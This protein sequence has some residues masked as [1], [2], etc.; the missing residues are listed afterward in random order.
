MK[1]RLVPFRM[2]LTLG[3]AGAMIILFGGL[4]LLLHTLVESSLDQAINRSLHTHAADLSSLVSGKQRLP[5][6]PESDGTF[7]QIIE[8]GTGHVLVATPGHELA[9]L[10]G[11]QLQHGAAHS[12]LLDEGHQ[13]RLL[14]EPVATNPA[15]VLVV[16]LSLSQRDGTLTTLSELL[17]A[18]GPVLLILTCIAGYVL[19]ERALAPVARMSAQ[20]GRISGAPRGQRLPVPEAHDEMHR[21]GE[22][23]NAL[24]DRVEE[25]LTRERSFVADAGHELRTPLA[26]LK[27]E[28]ELALDGDATRDELQER[29]RSA[30]EEVDRLTKIAQDLLFIARA[31]QGRLPL[32]KQ[33]LEVQDVLGAVAARFATPAAARGRTVSAE[34]GE[35]LAIEAD[36]AWLEQALTNLVS[37]ALRYGEG[38]VLL[39]ALQRGGE[40]ELHVLD[41]G[42]GFDEDFLRC[43]F[44]RFSRADAARA[45][46]GAGLGLSIV[47]AIADAH[48]GSACAANRPGGGAD[49]WVS[50]PPVS[51]ARV[52]QLGPTRVTA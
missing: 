30:A 33:Y 32:E 41:R 40:V 50:L 43:A 20:A 2:R 11:A 3:F 39:R 7:A 19:A 15:A 27:L 29:I 51:L 45:G 12:M 24:L 49:V 21:L 46:I 44:E 16:G 10:K 4:A 34:F 48:G 28:L 17:F 8:A 18:G 22:T 52:S 35:R 36:N 47:R 1:W 9:L 5:A 23:L 26:V 13:A 25:A 14:T 31:D 6:L 42:P 37:N 38:P